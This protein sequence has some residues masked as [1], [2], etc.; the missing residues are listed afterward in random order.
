MLINIISGVMSVFKKEQLK[1]LFLIA[2]LLLSQK[3]LSSLDDYIYGKRQPTYSNYGTIGLIQMPSARFFESG[4]IGFNWTSSDPYYKGSIMAYPFDWFEASYHYTDINNALYSDVR[5]FSGNQTYKDK[6]FDLKLRILKEATLIPEL[7]IGIRDIAGTGTFA[8]EYFVA[9]KFVSNVDFTLGLGWG[10]LSNNKFSNPLTKISNNFNERTLISNTQ[11]GDFSPGRYFSGP[12]GVFGGAEVFLPNFYGISL[13]IEYDAT[14]YSE[15]GFAFGQDSFS[16]AFEPVK[17]SESRINLALNY[18]VNDFLNLKAGIIKGNTFTLGFSI[19]AGLA[20]E[21]AVIPNN[22]PP[23]KVDKGS[24]WKRLNTQKLDSGDDSYLYK[25]TFKFLND[26]EL[27]VQNADLNI[28]KKE[29]TVEVAQNKYASHARKIGR[30]S[31][32]LDEVVP[33]NIDTF[34]IVAVNAGMKQHIAAVDRYA[35]NKYKDDK[36][37]ILAAKEILISEVPAEVSYK[38]SPTQNYPAFLFAIAPDIR[39]QIGGPD[40]FY[41][42]DFRLAFNSETMIKENQNFLFSASLGITNNFAELKLNS[43]SVLPHVRTDIV[44]YLKATSD[45]SINRAQYNYFRKLSPNVYSKIS[46]GLFENMFGGVGGEILYRPNQHTWAIGA[47]IWSVRQRDYEMMFD[48]LDYTTEI[49]FINMYYEE[50]RSKINLA[51]KGGRFLAGDS[52]INFDFHRRFQTGLRLGAFFSVTDISK[53]EFGEGSFD[54]GF[55]FHIPIESF[56]STFRSENVGW[57]L[58]PLTRDGAAYLAHSHHLFGVTDQAQAY[59][60]NR[61][62]KTLYD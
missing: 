2:F 40:G 17:Q 62:W 51:I 61:D 58:R 7:A 22:D 59:N 44:K 6:G 11:G 26:R 33:N 60:I 35:F 12:M 5:S 37:S 25:S 19:H 23:K 36:V 1:R 45:Y 4:T 21:G 20:F 55:Y 53:A 47:E 18:P 3:S 49:G 15:E 8:A 42:G 27:F 32:V 38:W 28:E 29:F 48:F 31:R 43:D 46:A 16:F 57:G 9:S 41:F 24:G 13:K 56:F 39:S 52:G 14:D 54:K 30:I 34:N 10:D 50:P